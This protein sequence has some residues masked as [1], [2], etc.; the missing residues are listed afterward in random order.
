MPN[1]NTKTTFALLAGTSA[2]VLMLAAPAHA[3]RRK[4]APIVFAGQGSAPQVNQYR[5]TVTPTP[6]SSQIQSNE[7]T[8]RVEFRY[9][10]QPDTFYGQGG[11]RSADATENPIA[12]S[13]AKAAIDVN[14]ARQY[15][16]ISPQDTYTDP[17]ITSGGFDA[18]AAAAQ[19]EAQRAAPQ[20]MRITA[21]SPQAAKPLG[22]PV[23]LSRTNVRDGATIS[24]EVGI[25]GAYGDGFEGQPTANGERFEQTGMTAAHPTLPLPSLVQVVNTQNGREIVVRVNDRGPFAG[26]R[27]ID[28]SQHAAKVLGYAEG[29]T[30]PVKV[31][32]LG[33]APVMQNT[34]SAT[35]SVQVESLP[36]FKPAPV[37]TVAYQEPNLGVPDPIGSFTPPKPTKQVAAGT[38]NIY[39]QAGSFADI[40]NAQR[41]NAALGRGMPVEIQEAR[42]RNADY[43]RVMIGPFPNRQQADTYRAHLADSG[44]AK[45]IVVAR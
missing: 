41:L 3:D 37:Q 13:S 6:Q 31:R 19:V 20:P 18:R 44:I 29:G 39:V 15:A 24:E 23:T 12:F 21:T 16:A 9:P 10:D 5:Q 2:A 22:R 30:A 11:A 4:P 17:A 42:V 26:G 33:P 25:A 32:Y 43:F 8:R 28:L 34:D 38:G 36:D 1:A 40:G 45:G 14:Q 27:I 35:Q 7:K